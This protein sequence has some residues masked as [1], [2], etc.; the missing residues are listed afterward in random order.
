MIHLIR[1]CAPNETVKYDQSVTQLGFESGPSIGLAILFKEVPT[2]L[3][4]GC[5]FAT[6]LCSHSAFSAD[7]G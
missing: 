4:D 3:V 6:T 7:A 1:M 5:K 2:K